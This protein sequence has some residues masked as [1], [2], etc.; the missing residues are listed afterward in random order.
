MVT[1]T[2]TTKRKVDPQEVA[3]LI[4]GTGALIFPW[5]LE[6]KRDSED[7]IL[8]HWNEDTGDGREET[9][10]TAEKVVSALESALDGEYLSPEGDSDVLSALTDSIGYLDAVGADIVLQIAVY[11]SVVF[12]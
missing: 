5:W 1:L 9:R 12:G 4:T 10:L 7:W 6:A 3:D 8:T 11:G 2:Y